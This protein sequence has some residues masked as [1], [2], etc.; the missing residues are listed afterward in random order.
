MCRDNAQFAK[1]NK[2]GLHADGTPDADD[3]HAAWGGR[4]GALVRA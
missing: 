2:I 4:C 1:F 3:L